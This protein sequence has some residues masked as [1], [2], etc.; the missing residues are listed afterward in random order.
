MLNVALVGAG[1]MGKRHAA[2]YRQ[3]DGVKL[4]AAVDI[5]NDAAASAARDEARTFRTLDQALAECDVDIVDVC[6]PTPFHGEHAVMAL[7]AGKH[8]LLEKPMARTLD[9]CDS[10]IAATDKAGTTAMVAH[11]LRFFPEFA[12]AKRAVDQGSVGRPA[13][14]RTSRGGLFPRGLDSWYADISQSGGAVLD[15][16]IHDFDWLRWMLGPAVRVYARGLAYAGR[17]GQD[18][19][20]VTIRFAGG[21]IAHVEGTWMRPSGFETKF[22]IAGSDG[23][24][25]YRSRDAASLRISRVAGPEDR[26]AVEVPESPLAEDPYLAQ[27]RHFVD[28]VQTGQTPMV[29]LADARAAVEIGLAALKS[30]ETGEPVMLENQEA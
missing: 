28:C 30:I 5:D 21:A 23:L 17:A 27:I 25:D 6:T 10:I 1:S 16:I 24:L 9:E 7:E 13:V 11:V 29:S 8:L 19:A 18:Y 15:L 2:C 26:A 22:E 4:A 12:Q 3:L 20:L 14:V